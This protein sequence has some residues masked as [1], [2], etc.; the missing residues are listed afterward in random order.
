MDIDINRCYKSAQN[1]VG[2]QEKEKELCKIYVLGSKASK[3]CIERFRKEFMLDTRPKL[4]LRLRNSV[5]DIEG[6]IRAKCMSA[7]SEEVLEQILKSD[8][9]KMYKLFGLVKE[10]KYFSKQLKT[11]VQ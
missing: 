5:E 11:L 1:F 10:V 6:E 3:V 8:L 2:I 4:P 7:P 9:R